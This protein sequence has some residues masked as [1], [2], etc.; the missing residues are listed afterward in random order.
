MR[1]TEEAGD[2]YQGW[3]AIYVDDFL[4]GSVGDL[5]DRVYEVINATWECGDLERVVSAEAGKPVRFD[6]L[7]LQ[8]N[9]DRTKLYVH[10][11]SYASDLVGRYQGLYT[12][13]A[14]PLLKPLTEAEPEDEVCQ[15][16]VRKCQQVIGEIL[17]LSVRTRPDLAYVCSRL[18]AVMTKRPKATFEAAMG[19]VGYIAATTGVGFVY[20]RDDVGPLSGQRR[21]LQRH[22]LLEVYTDASFAPECQ[23]SQEAAVIYWRGMTIHWSSSRQA[24]IAQSTCEAE[25]VSTV[26]GANLGQSFVPLAQEIRAGES[27]RC[28]IL[29]DNMA[30]IGIL[31]CDASS[32]RT[33]HLRIR[34]NALR[35]TSSG[36]LPTFQESSI[37]LTLEP[38]R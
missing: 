11:S 13:Q 25:L 15:E 29:N 5:V 8:W 6:G 9:Q 31:T 35:V 28:Q 19:T 7:E 12:E 10:Q 17:Y 33:R 20:S 37:Q 3:I 16:T 1:K 26:F 18:A 34:A 22:G 27:I 14:V 38:R 32:W 21:G 36:K 30:A 23:R 24:F 4:G 2:I